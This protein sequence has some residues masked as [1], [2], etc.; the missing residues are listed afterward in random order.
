MGLLLNS[1][2]N[3]EKCV[4]HPDQDALV[5]F[6]DGEQWIW[7]CIDCAADEG[8]PLALQLKTSQLVK[9]LLLPASVD[10]GIF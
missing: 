8:Y 5:K 1:E 3:L 9:Q 4:R 7:L 2:F 10:R 6:Y